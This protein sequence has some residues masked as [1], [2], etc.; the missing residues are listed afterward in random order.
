MR[1]VRARVDDGDWCELQP[2]SPGF[3]DTPLTGGRL[4]KGE[5]TIEIEAIDREGRRGSQR[6]GFFVDPTGRYT[7]VPAVRPIVTATAFC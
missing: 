5:H 4:A 6:S 7:A 1:G 2:R 3:W